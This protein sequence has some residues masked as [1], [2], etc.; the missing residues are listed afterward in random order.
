MTYEDRG[1]VERKKK[2]IRKMFCFDIR[3]INFNINIIFLA[4]S[5][6]PPTA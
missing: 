1:I 3:L 2:H 5:P 6:L 4:P